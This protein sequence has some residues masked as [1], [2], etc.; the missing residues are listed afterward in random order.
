MSQHHQH[1]QKGTALG[2]LFAGSSTGW[3]AV[4]MH[5]FI[6]HLLMYLCTLVQLLIECACRLPWK[7]TTDPVTDAHLIRFIA[8][9][10][11]VLMVTLREHND[12]SHCELCFP[13][14]LP[15]DEHMTDAGRVT[16]GLIVCF[17]ATQK[18]I[19]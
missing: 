3:G 8:E 6:V 13:N 9:T 19:H 17:D 16:K 11:L 12:G 2:P 5:K 14:W 18:K 1:H 7:Q 15:F 10:S 4:G